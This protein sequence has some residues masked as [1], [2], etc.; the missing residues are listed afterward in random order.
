[1]YFTKNDFKHIH[2]HIKLLGRSKAILA[3]ARKAKTDA[4]HKKAQIKMKKHAEA[5]IKDS[6]KLDKRAK[7]AKKRGQ[8]LLK[9]YGLS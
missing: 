5:L 4:E 2:K 8:A 6:A 9:K 3:A 1:M 7:A